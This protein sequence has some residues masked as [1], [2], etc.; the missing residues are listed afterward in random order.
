MPICQ[1]YSDNLL[2]QPENWLLAF[3]LQYWWECFVNSWCS[4]S[5]GAVIYPEKYVVAVSRTIFNGSIY[6]KP[7]IEALLVRGKPSPSEPGR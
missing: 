2:L 7:V 6:C 4:C 5:K 3:P 1:S